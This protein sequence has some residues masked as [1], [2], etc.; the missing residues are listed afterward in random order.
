MGA[1]RFR[2]IGRARGGA[3]ALGGG[4][5]SAVARRTVDLFSP[6]WGRVRRMLRLRRVVTVGP[7][8]YT[9]LTAEPLHRALS[10]NGGGY[11]EYLVDFR[12]G[13][14][15]MR[16]RCTSTRVYADLA[17]DPREEL[18]GRLAE[19]VGPGMRVLLVG[20]GTG[21]VADEA[22]RLVGPSGSIVSVEADEESARFA[23]RRYSRANAAFEAG[24]V[25]AL[26]GELDGAFDAAV[27]IEA[28]PVEAGARRV[29]VTEAVRVTIGPVLLAIRAETSEPGADPASLCDASGGSAG[30]TPLRIGVAGRAGD[31]AIVEVGRDETG[32]PG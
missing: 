25:K 16:I 12:G 14:A 28:T 13:G 7:V 19:A 30:E 23:A 8:R 3:D 10:R 11:K 5:M 2:D 29:L 4:G 27:V 1:D 32:A 9:E 20:A 22:A 18:A 31:W 26:A 17:R 15:R 24:G 6:F 21:E